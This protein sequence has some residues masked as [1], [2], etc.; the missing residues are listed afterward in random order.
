MKS[1]TDN[2]ET[3][4]SGA[5]EVKAVETLHPILGTNGEMEAA[6]P[7]PVIDSEGNDENSFVSFSS[8]AST[9]FDTMLLAHSQNLRHEVDNIKLNICSLVKIDIDKFATVTPSL[10][11]NCST[12]N[13]FTLADSLL[14]LLSLSEKVCAVIGGKR[15]SESHSQDGQGRRLSD[16]HCQEVAAVAAAASIAGNV[17]LHDSI[18]AILNNV[19]D[20]KK[21]ERKEEETL[22]E[23]QNQL[24]QLVLSV[25]NYKRRGSNV[26]TPDLPDFNVSIPN[27][28]AEEP[29]DVTQAQNSDKVNLF[30]SYT[31]NFIDRTTGEELMK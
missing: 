20:I 1:D 30:T 16:S 22:K 25:E 18:Q 10:I 27:L 19:L 12:L 31:E 11:K 6:Q 2:V 29:S 28:R 7:S 23:I 21:T 5:L 9:P 15:L 17:V 3:S 14:S 4:P 8:H 26:S 24:D 13:K